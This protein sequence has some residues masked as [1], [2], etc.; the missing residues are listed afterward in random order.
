MEMELSQRD[1]GPTDQKQSKK[2]K[3]KISAETLALSDKIC[4]VKLKAQSDFL[5]S[6][7]LILHSWETSQSSWSILCFADLQV[8][9]AS[10]RAACLPL[11]LAKA[12]PST[13]FSLDIPGALSP[14]TGFLLPL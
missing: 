3:T 7:T 10:Q 4:I 12:S 6:L 2:E 8:V 11:C 13:G 9:P 1:R 14:C 5:P